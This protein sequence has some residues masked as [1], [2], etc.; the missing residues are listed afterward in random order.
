MY[1]DFFSE[2]TGAGLLTLNPHASG[3][4][5]LISCSKS[6]HATQ[7]W[8]VMASNRPGK[9]PALRVGIILNLGPWEPCLR[10]LLERSGLRFCLLL[11]VW[12]LKACE[13]GVAWSHPWPRLG[14]AGLKIK[15]TQGK[16]SK[17]KRWRTGDNF[18]HTSDELQLSWSV[19]F[20]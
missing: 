11:R 14:R 18:L 13:P 19:D 5:G 12:V 2:Q 9:G 10:W 6:E 1:P 15:P 8:P 17:A 20:V 3:G 7:V 4:T 16:A